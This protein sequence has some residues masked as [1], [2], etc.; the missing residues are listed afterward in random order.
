[1]YIKY[2]IFMNQD[3]VSSTKHHQWPLKLH[4]YPHSSFE[5]V[6]ILLWNLNWNFD[7]HTSTKYLYTALYTRSTSGCDESKPSSLA[8]TSSPKCWSKFP[9]ITTIFHI[10]SL[11]HLKSNKEKQGKVISK[12]PCRQAQHCSTWWQIHDQI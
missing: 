9:R 4:L 11:R 5:K 6:S 3:D 10:F 7:L 8:T 12:K 2:Y 1:M